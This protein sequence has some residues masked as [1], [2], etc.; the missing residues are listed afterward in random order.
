M[1]LK[2]EWLAA[3]SIIVIFLGLIFI[4]LDFKRLRLIVWSDWKDYHISIL[5]PCNNKAVFRLFQSI[6]DFIE[7]RIISFESKF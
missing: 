5:I 4:L 7:H 2:K 6:L 1:R 3:F